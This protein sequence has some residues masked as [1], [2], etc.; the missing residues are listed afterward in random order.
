MFFS[1]VILSSLLV[2]IYLRI[3]RKYW[4]ATEINNC[5]RN[6]DIMTLGKMFQNK[7]EYKIMVM[8]LCGST[9]FSAVVRETF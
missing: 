7:F 5:K 9:I 1:G 6:H 4:E 3:R 2:S 8:L